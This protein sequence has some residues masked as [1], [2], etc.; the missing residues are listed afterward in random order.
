MTHG[1]AMKWYAA[2]PGMKLHIQRRLRTSAMP[3]VSSVQKCGV[4]CGARGGLAGSLRATRNAADTMN[5]AASTAI[6]APGLK[7]DE[8]RARGG[9]AEHVADVDRQAH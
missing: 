7:D 6:A 5:V 9:R 3:P 1:S 8:Q 4:S 2:K